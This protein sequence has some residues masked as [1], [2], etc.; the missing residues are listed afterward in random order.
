MEDDISGIY[1][2]LDEKTNAID[3]LRFAYRFIIQTD[4]DLIYWKWGC[5]ALHGALYGFAICACRGSNNELVAPIIKKGKRKGERELISI[6]KALEYCQNK[7]VMKRYVFSEELNIKDYQSDSLNWLINE[8]RNE[9]MHFTPK[10]WSI[11]IHGLPQ[12]ILDILDIIYSLVFDT[13]NIILEQD[14]IEKI[15]KL[16]H[17]SRVYI[18]NSKLYDESDT[19]INYRYGIL[20]YNILV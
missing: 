9:F 12:I 5:I 18:T 7:N 3:Y 15:K 14:Q 16:I 1:L 17:D 13:K 6:G 2:R 11:E 8:L 20:K 4:K 10:G 19:L